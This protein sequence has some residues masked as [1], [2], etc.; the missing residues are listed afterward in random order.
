MLVAADFKKIDIISPGFWKTVQLL[1]CQTFNATIKSCFTSFVDMTTVAER[2]SEA[3]DGL[4]KS[5]LCYFN[6]LS[7]LEM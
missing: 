1:C 3:R 5:K 4:E 2:D 7:N 6:Q